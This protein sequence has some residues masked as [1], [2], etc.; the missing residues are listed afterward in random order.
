M[1]RRN[2]PL[3]HITL[4]AQNMK[5]KKII[6]IGDKKISQGTRK[7]K[8]YRVKKHDTRIMQYQMRVSKVSADSERGV[9]NRS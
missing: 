6:H 7:W 1:T 2:I 3:E 4:E 9:K 5:R 8:S